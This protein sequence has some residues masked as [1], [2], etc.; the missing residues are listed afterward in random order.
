MSNDLSQDLRP[1]VRKRPQTPSDFFVL[2]AVAALPLTQAL[3][4]DLGFPLKISEV[5][6]LAATPLRLASLGGETRTQSDGG[7]RPLVYAFFFVF[8]TCLSL[9]YALALQKGRPPDQGQYRFGA[10]VDGLLYLAYLILAVATMLLVADITRRRR[11]TVIKVYLRGAVVAASYAF[12]VNLGLPP[13][14]GASNQSALV[15][16]FSLLRAG[17]FLE[18][19]FFGLYLLTALVLAFCVR[20]LGVAA[21]LSGAVLVSLSTPNIAF[22]A[23]LWL[24]V[25]ARSAKSKPSNL[26]V[27]IPLVAILLLTPNAYW[28]RAI[29]EKVNDPSSQSVIER[30][31]SADAALGMFLDNPFTGVGVGQYGLWFREYRPSYVPPEFLERGRLIANNVYAQVAAEQGAL[32]LIPFLALVVQVLRTAWRRISRLAGVGVMC[33]LVVLNA[34]PSATAVFVWAFFGAILGMAAHT[35]S[36]E[37]PVVPPTPTAR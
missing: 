6:L 10:D 24:V 13:L 2:V 7:N 33:V 22:M 29:G 28:Y 15:G 37:E 21:I 4:I 5:A 18:G 26:L 35:R 12:Y 8:T 36:R 27:V 34:F 20:R 19:N 30:R 17:T 9:F 31:G 14:P 16:G 3:T 1:S 23:L 11:D 25:L 32:G